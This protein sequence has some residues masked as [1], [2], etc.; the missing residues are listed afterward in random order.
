MLQTITTTIKVEGKNKRDITE[1]DNN[2]KINNHV[3][4]INDAKLQMV[5]RQFKICTFYFGIFYNF[6]FNLALYIFCPI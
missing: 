4:H 2:E 6:E 1:H 5:P 3:K